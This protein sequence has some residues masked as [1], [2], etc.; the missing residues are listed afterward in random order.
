MVHHCD[1]EQ[2]ERGEKSETQEEENK[3]S[4]NVANKLSKQVNYHSKK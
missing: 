4:W 2:K 3:T 1:R